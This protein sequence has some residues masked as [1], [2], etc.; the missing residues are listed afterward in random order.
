MKR[1][2]SKRKNSKR[3]KSRSII[4]MFNQSPP[5]FLE[6]KLLEYNKSLHNLIN[7]LQENNTLHRVINDSLA[8]RFHKSS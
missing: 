8:S 6:N 2:K 3:R 5:A 7:I 4:F 1:K